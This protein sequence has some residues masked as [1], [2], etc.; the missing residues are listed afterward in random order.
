M[1]DC[2]IVFMTAS[3]RGEA[4]K[5]AKSLVEKQLA[6]CVQI[7]ADIQSMYWWEGKICNEKEVFFTAKT[8]EELFPALVQEVKS[9]HS[10]K[11][12]EVVFV[13]IK[14]GSHEYMDWIH[15]VTMK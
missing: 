6:A 12:P 7:F 8:T 10:Y 2:G 11:V 4:E 13:P 14:N 1:T 5:I 3:S 15:E 9:L